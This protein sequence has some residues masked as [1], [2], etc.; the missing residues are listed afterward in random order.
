M[1]LK[2]KKKLDRYRDNIVTVNSNNHEVKIWYR[3]SLTTYY[4]Y[5]SAV[6]QYIRIQSECEETGKWVT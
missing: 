1:P 6:R 4:A 5:G 3:D 2:K